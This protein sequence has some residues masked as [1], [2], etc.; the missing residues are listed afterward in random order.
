[1]P[2]TMT[3]RAS[4]LLDESMLN[5]VKER[6]ITVATAIATTADDFIVFGSLNII[7]STLY[8]ELEG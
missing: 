5:A 4:T 7:R 3:R 2:R 6:L 1:M 8:F